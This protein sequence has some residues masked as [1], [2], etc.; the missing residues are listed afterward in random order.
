MSI[1]GKK[2]GNAKK[3]NGHII[4]TGLLPI[5]LALCLMLS[6]PYYAKNYAGIIGLGL[7]CANFVRFHG[8]ANLNYSNTG[9]PYMQ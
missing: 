9:V 8:S 3:H 7:V 5:M 6:G 4:D 2:L 1:I